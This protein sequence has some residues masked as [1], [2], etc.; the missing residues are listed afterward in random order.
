MINLNFL[1]SATQAAAESQ[2]GNP[3]LHTGL[4][5]DDGHD[6]QVKRRRIAP[7][8]FRNSSWDLLPVQS[9]NK[10]PLPPRPATDIQYNVSLVRAHSN[11]I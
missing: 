4:I 10:G 5:D 1:T 11:Y 3:D 2:I 8:R 9:K 6:L 7:E